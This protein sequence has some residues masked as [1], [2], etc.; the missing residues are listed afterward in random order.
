[1]KRNSMA[2]QKKDSWRGGV[3]IRGDLGSHSLA[4]H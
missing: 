4:V 2:G 1:M 3:F